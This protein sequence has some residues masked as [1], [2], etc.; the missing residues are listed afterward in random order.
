MTLSLSRLF[1]LFLV[2]AG[3]CLSTPLRA[4]EE[5]ELSGS[6]IVQNSGTLILNGRRIVL[7][8]ITTLDCDQQ[9]W[10]DK[11]AWPCGEEASMALKHF[12]EGQFVKCIVKSDLD[13]GKVSA[14]C[15]RM[16][17]NEPHDVAHY[18]VRHGW[19]LNEDDESGGL[20]ESDEEDAHMKRRGVWSGNFQTPEDWREGVQRFVDHE[21]KDEPDL[22]DEDQDD[23]PE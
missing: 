17:G 13:N 8:G 19:A 7:W 1:I 3:T 20:Y 16:R 18:L 14:Q 5:I 11:K 21:A 2:L 12:V 23:L 10:Q 6:P 4:E 9:C 22:L 15:F